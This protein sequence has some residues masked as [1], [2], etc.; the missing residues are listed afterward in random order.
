[1]VEMGLW[2]DNNLFGLSSHIL[3]PRHLPAHWL[4]WDLLMSDSDIISSN[5]LT[6]GCYSFFSYL[7]LRLGG[8]ANAIEGITV[9]TIYCNIILLFSLISPNL[10]TKCRLFYVQ[11]SFINKFKKTHTRITN[12]IWSIVWTRLTDMFPYI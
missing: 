7:E 4:T 3:G 6:R 5:L 8:I 10:F 2:F 9:K 1:M 12:K 11:F